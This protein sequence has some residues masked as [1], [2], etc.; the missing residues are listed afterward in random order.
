FTYVSNVVAANLAAFRAQDPLRG[1]ALNVGTGRRVS[2][3]DLVAACNAILG[4]HL[5]PDFQP[6]RPG[7][8]RDSQA[9]LDRIG[10][11]LGYRP[12]VDFEEGLRRTIEATATVSAPAC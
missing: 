8:V 10:A 3:L 1:V 6:A 9:S 4:T 12:Q 5:E 7:D 11:V 2:L